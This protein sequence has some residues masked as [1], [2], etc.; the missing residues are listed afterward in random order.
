MTSNSIRTLDEFPTPALLLD[1]DVLDANLHRMAERTQQ[2][3][4]ALR[5]HV[6][7]HKCVEVAERQREQGG[8]GITVSTLYEAQLFA[9]H[10]FTDVTWAFPVIPDRAEEAAGL[11]GQFR[12]GLTVD[13][14]EAIQALEATGQPLRIWIKVDCGYGRAGVDPRGEFALRVAGAVHESR[15]LSLA[16]ILTH[17]GHAYDGGS[18][19]EIR[20]VAD[21]ERDVMVAFAAKLQGHGIPVEEVSV[22]STPTIA[23]VRRLEGITE[24]RP[25]NYAFY[26][27]GQV[28]LGS[29]R[30]SD[31]ALTVL[32]S[33]IS[34]Q[35]GRGYCVVDAGA[36]ALSKDVGLGGEPP[37]YGYP[38]DDYEAGRLVPGVTITS[39]SQEHGILNRPLRVGTRVRI[40]PNHSC[41][42][43][44]CFDR[45]YVV[46]GQEVVDVWKVWRDR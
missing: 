32:T 31:C 23:Q 29:C 16:G 41:L 38:F 5:P 3:G 26:D 12:L 22:G 7:T 1:R 19:E 33:V 25:G 2:L 6:K 42:T 13:S 4:V 21:E 8:R 15:T 10:G 34:S 9:D 37:A 14:L 18:P 20:A 27:Y 30:V 43:A 46:R 45:Y 11:A 28:T 35:P 24:V 39:V 44:A 17:G 40:L 36:L